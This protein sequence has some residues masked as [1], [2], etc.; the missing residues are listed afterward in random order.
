MNTELEALD[1]CATA[2]A[3]R[4][5]ELT[6]LE[7]TQGAL[8]RIAARNAPINAVIDTFVTHAFDQ[9][10]SCSRTG[11][12]A[13]VP[14]LLK[15]TIEYPGFRYAIGSRRFIHRIGSTPQPW[16]EAMKAE[17]AVIVGKTATP[18]YGLMD[19]T[20]PVAFGP[21]R[22]PWRLDTTAGGSSGGAAAAVAAGMTA[23][24]HGSDGG[25]SIRF[26]AHCCGVFGFK[27]TQS[28][29]ATPPP[30]FDPRL[31]PTPVRH[32][33]TRTVRD[34][35]LL[36]A[37]A[38]AAHGGEPASAARRWVQGPSLNR[39]RVA[40]IDTPLHG[41][42]LA[43][44]HRRGLAQAA[45][46]L[47]ALGHQV[48]DPQP[49]PFDGPAVQA[50]FWD[51][52]AN[53]VALEVSAMS[54]ADARLHLDSAEE[55]TRGL[56]RLG[57][58]LTPERREAFIRRQLEAAAQ[59]ELLL[60]RDADVLLTPV[61]ARFAIPIGHHHPNLP[62]E[63]LMDRLGSNV[64]FTHMQ[65]VA[66]QPAMSVPLFH[67]EDSGLPVGVHL[68]AARGHDERL[69][70][71]AYELEAARPWIGRKPGFAAGPARN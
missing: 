28:R 57:M 8:E 42:A 37:I 14:L 24:A 49:W 60:T 38:C 43:P 1:A 59:M 22:N 18:E 41:G 63:T 58:A 27:P 9:A 39:L 3:V 47:R 30:P 69:F 26:P 45:E 67:D 40:V 25:G 65:N 11:L 44:E 51:R 13:G 5:G 66:G 19:V 34:S 33:L 68:A 64:A 36:F 7:A 20:E 56:Y 23:I 21:T 70:A 52:W 31:T 4:R 54:E 15:D 71:L 10:A 35:A 32:A 6:P 46:L 55:W 48:S 53:S 2:E 61:S 62:F 12:L 16:V 29:N 50:A 17:G